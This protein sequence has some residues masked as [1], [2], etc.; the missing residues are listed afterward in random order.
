MVQSCIYH[1]DRGPW[2][3]Q[4]GKTSTDAKRGYTYNIKDPSGVVNK[5]FL[6]ILLRFCT[7]THGVIEPYPIQLK[8]CLDKVTQEREFVVSGKTGTLTIPPGALDPNT[9]TIKV[10][11][12]NSDGKYSE[13]NSF[14]VKA[15]TC[16]YSID[17]LYVPCALACSGL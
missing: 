3:C 8:Q 16:T 13:E 15:G 14:S 2:L 9:Y 1:I 12:I 6:T 10:V 5:C 17:T 7:T 11:D 4:I